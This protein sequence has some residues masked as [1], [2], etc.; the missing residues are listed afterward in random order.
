[1]KLQIN[2]IRRMQQLAGLIVEAFNSFLD[3]NMGGWIREYIDDVVEDNMGEPESLNLEY[4]SD[5]DIA[6]NLALSKLSQEQFPLYISDDSKLASGFIKP[7]G[8]GFIMNSNGETTVTPEI[9]Q[10]FNDNYGIIDI[11]YIKDFFTNASN[12][13]MITDENDISNYKK[14]YLIDT[15]SNQIGNKE[16]FF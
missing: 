15:E 5:F 7:K 6:F 8:I 16:N 12:W 9:V 4:R 2:E 1:M 14:L 10:I 3:T 13:K 11:N